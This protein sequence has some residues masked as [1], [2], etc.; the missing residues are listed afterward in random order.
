MHTTYTY[1]TGKYNYT[2]YSYM[3]NTSLTSTTRISDKTKRKV[4]KIDVQLCVK[5]GT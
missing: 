1:N 2:Y 3:N 4:V 5:D